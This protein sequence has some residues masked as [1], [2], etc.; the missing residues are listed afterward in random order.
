MKKILT[1]LF[2]ALLCVG[3]WADDW[4]V[5]LP[6]HSVVSYS[7]TAESAFE[8]STSADDNSHWY[9]LQQGRG[10]LTPVVDMGD[11]Q[12]IYRTSG[13]VSSVITNGITHTSNAL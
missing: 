11:S 13:N 10:K 1:L 3:G 9:V 7:E 8:V 12:T 2:L 6:E 4:T 5:S